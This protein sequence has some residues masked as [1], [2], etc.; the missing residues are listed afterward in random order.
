[1]SIWN[2]FFRH[3]DKAAMTMEQG[4]YATQH[5][6]HAPLGELDFAPLPLEFG[7]DDVYAQ[8]YTWPKAQSDRYKWY[9]NSYWGNRL[10]PSD[11]GIGI[12]GWPGHVPQKMFWTQ[13]SP[14]Q[15]FAQQWSLNRGMYPYQMSVQQAANYVQQQQA[16]WKARAGQAV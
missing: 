2:I 5:I 13:Y 11:V 12:A 15:S 16:A 6:M 10:P 14:E 4:E 3:H 1:M 9:N 7:R 8:A